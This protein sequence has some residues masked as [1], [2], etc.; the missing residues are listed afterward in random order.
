MHL[1]DEFPRRLRVIENT[2]IPMSDGC[3]LAARIWLPE[4]AEG[5]PVPAVLD[6]IPYRKNDRSTSD[7]SHYEYIAGNGYAFVRVDLRG[8]GDSDGLLHGEYLKQE[9]DDG[10]EVIAWIASQPWCTGDVGMIG[11]SWGGFNGL[12]IAARQPPELKA[13]ISVYSTDDRYED[14]LHHQGGCVMSYTLTWA[15]TMFAYNARPPDP[16]HVGD[17]WREMWFE[18]IENDTPWVEEWLRHPRK[19]EF[20]KHGSVRENYD[21]IQ[22]PVYMVGGWSDPYAGVVPRFLAGYSGPRKGLIG[23]WA[24]GYPYDVAPKPTIGFLQESL[25]W[26]DHWL[27]GIDTGIMDEPM[28]RVWMQEA[29]PPKVYHSERPGR[30]VAEPSWPS[31]N[32]ETRT[33]VLNDGTLDETPAPEVRLDHK[34]VGRAGMD[35]G[36]WVPYGRLAEWPGDQRGDDAL[37]LTFTSAP[38][39]ERLEI[40]GSSAAR[41]TVSADRPNAIIAVRLCDVSPTGSSTLIT[42]R[43]L[44]LT[45]RNSDEEPEPLRS[46][47]AAGCD[48]LRRSRRAQAAAS[49]VADLLALDVAV[50]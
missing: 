10:I 14:E 38:L 28:L 24:H 6:Y 34:G 25:R 21:D 37:S 18:R 2:W 4:D 50:T 5:H 32:V 39:P 7:V 23:P 29:V 49:R 41:L 13:V 17:R 26:W 27:K 1:R 8:S 12:Q 30:W 11:I 44:N 46:H 36:D 47:G 43:M 40:L 42:R 22:C 9:Q 19:D 15:S 16:R 35:A 48:G 45:H 31:P 33:Y 20:W 3:R